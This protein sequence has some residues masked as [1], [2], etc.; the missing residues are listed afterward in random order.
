[1]TA[2]LRSDV[3]EWLTSR[4]RYPVLGTVGEDGAPR[5]SVMWALVQDDDTILM[6]TRRDRQKARDI[7]RDPRAS[8]CFE[9]GYQY[10]TLEGIAELRADP[11]LRD[12]LRLRA[13]YA[14]DYDF[15]P[16][17]GER[18]SIIFT[19]TRVLTHFHRL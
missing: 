16:Q 3:R 17:R 11:D 7:A 9:D 19:V 2:R 12:I 10:V 4:A 8:L 6:N 1:M 18:V 5:L 15:A 14:D 13:Y